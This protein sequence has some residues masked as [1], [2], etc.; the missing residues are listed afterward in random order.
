LYIVHMKR[1]TAS[2]ARQNWF[3]LLDDVLAGEVVAIVRKGQRI[4]IRRD[5]SARFARR[6]ATDYSALIRVED[7]DSI[8]DVGWE[9]QGPEG[10]IEPVIK[11][12]RP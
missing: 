4:V 11:P 8:D 9:W 5:D 1:M 7:V 12:R 6:K 2:E 10:D 3:R